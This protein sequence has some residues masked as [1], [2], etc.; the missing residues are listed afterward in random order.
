MTGLY[1]ILPRQL[2]KSVSLA[3]QIRGLA[4]SASPGELPPG[5]TPSL[6]EEAKRW[7]SHHNGSK[8]VP[9]QYVDVSFARSSGP[10]GQVSVH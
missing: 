8:V 1:T 2:L 5:W 4:Q 7:I 6:L 3:P 10:G 9:R